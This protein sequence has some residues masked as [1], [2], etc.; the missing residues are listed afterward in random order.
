M[1]TFIKFKGRQRLWVCHCLLVID[2]VSSFLWILSAVPSSPSLFL[3]VSS[4]HLETL[5]A[6]DPS[7]HPGTPVSRF[8]LSFPVSHR[9]PCSSTLAGAAPLTLPLFPEDSNACYR[10]RS[11]L[12]LM[13]LSADVFVLLQPPCKR[14]SFHHTSSSMGTLLLSADR[15]S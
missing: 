7:E 3:C 5:S 12:A 10:W 11:L 14:P 2:P 4:R 13:L 1:T 15:R 6:W 9:K 8:S